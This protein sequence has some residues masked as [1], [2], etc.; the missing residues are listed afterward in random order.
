M[1]NSPVYNKVDE[2]R[3]ENKR[4]WTLKT[5][6]DQPYVLRPQCF[7]KNNKRASSHHVMWMR[8]VTRLKR[9][10]EKKG[11]R[12]WHEKLIQFITVKSLLANDKQEGKRKWVRKNEI[13]SLHFIKQTLSFLFYFQQEEE[14]FFKRKR[15]SFN[16]VETTI[17]ILH[18]LCSTMTW[19]QIPMRAT[20]AFIALTWRRKT[21][22]ALEECVTF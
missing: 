7:E 15:N 17:A 22:S 9:M 4:I 2:E 18:N 13:V 6:V 14:G 3:G 1:I 11:N 10:K 21:K 12:N 16:A 8:I 19:K 20:E 5:R